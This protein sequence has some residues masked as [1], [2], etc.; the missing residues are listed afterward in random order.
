M[1]K[2]NRTDRN[3]NGTYLHVVIKAD[4]NEKLPLYNAFNWINKVRSY[5]LGSF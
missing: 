3:K 5:C 1:D 4:Q 2:L